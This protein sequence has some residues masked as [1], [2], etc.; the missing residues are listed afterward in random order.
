MTTPK[1]IQ[2]ATAYD[3]RD[4]PTVLAALLS[5]GTL[6]VRAAHPTGEWKAVPLP[7]PCRPRLRR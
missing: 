4:E 6:W 1:V 2:I 3:G 5:D 7:P